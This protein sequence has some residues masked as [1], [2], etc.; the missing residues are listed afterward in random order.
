MKMNH[1]AN[2][3]NN[4]KL[5][6]NS[7]PILKQEKYKDVQIS[8][9]HPNLINLFKIL[10]FIDLFYLF[11]NEDIVY[12]IK[13]TVDTSSEDNVQIF[14]YSSATIPS[15]IFY[16][17]TNIINKNH[18]DITYTDNK[19]SKK[20]FIKTNIEKVDIILVWKES[21]INANKMFFECKKIENMNLL[22]FQNIEIS[23]ATEMFKGCESLTSINLKLKKT[24]TTLNID[25]IFCNCS[26]LS[27]IYFSTNNGPINILKNIFDGS[28]QIKSINF[29]KIDI[30]LITDMSGI[31]S[32]LKN[33]KTIR[34]NSLITNV[35]TS[36][37]SMFKKCTSLTN[38]YF[39]F[40]SENS[41]KITDM[42][43]MFQS[44]SKLQKIV[45]INFD[46]SYT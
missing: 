46:T 21:E 11:L 1:F 25:C 23:D 42:S 36:M 10:L 39:Y 13:L 8:K 40:N 15:S 4:S 34:L 17:G 9:T 43:Y 32:N 27:T 38:V 16:N 14:D 41:L 24:S 29:D 19:D 33:L 6:K 26:K 31:F 12:K 35:E 30:S 3:I 18:D 45:F 2:E 7:Y 44:C 5:P 20:L 28:S 37:K 22:D